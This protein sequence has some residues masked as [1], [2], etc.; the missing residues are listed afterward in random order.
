[1]QWLS[2]ML[3]PVWRT[4]RRQDLTWVDKHLSMHACIA[5]GKK[6]NILGCGLPERLSPMCSCTYSHS[7][8][9][10]SS[11]GAMNIPGLSERLLWHKAPWAA[12]KTGSWSMHVLELCFTGNANF[13]FDWRNENDRSDSHVSCILQSSTVNLS[14]GK[15]STHE[16]PILGSSISSA[17]WKSLS[18]YFA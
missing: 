9:E 7:T 16:T 2:W 3:L 6:L 4:I 8:C 15:A 10:W 1:M 17:S 13:D 5:I 11:W 12:D 18:K 14:R